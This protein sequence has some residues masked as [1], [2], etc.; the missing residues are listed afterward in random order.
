MQHEN[1]GHDM[2][3]RSVALILNEDFG[4]RVI[5]LS[6][7]MPV[8]IVSSPA[9]ESAVRAAR[10]SYDEGEAPITVLLARPGED[11]ASFLTRAMYAI[12][13]HHGEASQAAPYDTL[14]VQGTTEI[15]DKE[16]AADLGFKVIAATAEGF[17]AEK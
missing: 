9:N 2:A 4:D 1:G 12:D 5:A 8:W 16:L 13:E 3:D 11:A 15:P 10:G 6:R 7:Q 14:W 17:R